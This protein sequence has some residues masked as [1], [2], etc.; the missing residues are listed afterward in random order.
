[1][2]DCNTITIFHSNDT[3]CPVTFSLFI[4]NQV[5][6]I[7]GIGFHVVDDIGS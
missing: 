2:S 7:V 5:L 4:N 6:F 3:Y 1:M